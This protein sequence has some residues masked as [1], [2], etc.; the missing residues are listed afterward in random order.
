MLI[1]GFQLVAEGLGLIF[2]CE[3]GAERAAHAAFNAGALL[4]WFS[5]A[6]PFRCHSD[7]ASHERLPLST[8]RWILY[9]SGFSF[10]AAPAAFTSRVLELR[11]RG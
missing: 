2:T 10:N 7:V 3:R 6:R 5:A 11:L 1:F 9:P 8:T 4:T